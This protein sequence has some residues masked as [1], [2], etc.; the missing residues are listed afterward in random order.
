MAVYNKYHLHRK[1]DPLF[2][3]NKEK[4]YCLVCKKSR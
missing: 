4:I 2:L 1:K 3:K